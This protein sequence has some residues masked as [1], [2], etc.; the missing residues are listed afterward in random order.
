MD[1]RK[2]LI[3]LNM[4]FWI[5]LAWITVSA[6]AWMW[7]QNSK[8][9]TTGIEAVTQTDTGVFF[10]ATGSEFYIL[11]N[12]EN[13][14]MRSSLKDMGIFGKVTDIAA[15]SENKVIIG[16][17]KE[18]TLKLCEPW[19]VRCD[20]FLNKN[21]QAKNLYRSNFSFTID[22]SAKRLYVEEQKTQKVD[23]Y[24]LSGNFINSTQRIKPAFSVDRIF[25]AFNS[26]FNNNLPQE[27]ASDLEEN[28]SIINR[29][30]V[31]GDTQLLNTPIQWPVHIKKSADNRLWIKGDA[32]QI[33]SYLRQQKSSTQS[34]NQ[35]HGILGI[36][37]LNHYFTVFEKGKFSLLSVSY[38]GK[39]LGSFGGMGLLERMSQLEGKYTSLQTFSRFILG[40]MLFSI[41]VMLIL[42]HLRAKYRKQVVRTWTQHLVGND[43]SSMEE[44]KITSEEAK[45]EPQLEDSDILWIKPMPQHY[46]HTQ[47]IFFFLKFCIIGCIALALFSGYSQVGLSN[48]NLLILMTGLLLL[49]NLAHFYFVTQQN[50]TGE[51]GTDGKH[52]WL[53]DYQGRTVMAHPSEVTFT[54]RAITAS[55]VTVIISESGDYG[56]NNQ[57]FPMGKL[58]CHIYPL[59]PA[60][61][62]IS[63]LKMGMSMLISRHPK[64][65]SPV[66][67]TLSGLTI[68]GLISFS[69]GALSL[70]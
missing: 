23:A 4:A 7:V 61:N 25:T 14:L 46:D 44:I 15:I 38:S 53:R 12:Q 58:M 70:I 33:I 13:I 45:N 40:E 64:V 3:W 20:Y 35:Q 50:I 55:G 16:D 49:T 22:H 1:K 47:K 62:K 67:A 59:L 36:K 42:G 52:L 51:I 5:G 24:T 19:I 31:Y 60:S 48:V 66:V 17:A 30:D 8:E 43:Y 39:I 9:Q 10:L 57:I 32:S 28:Q 69:G 56:G 34:N 65:W 11:D 41:L 68:L 26:I 27:N 54:D 37:P 63:P 18:G 29:D 6:I 2:K 21:N